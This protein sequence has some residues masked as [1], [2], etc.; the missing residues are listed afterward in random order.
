MRK[1]LYWYGTVAGI[2]VC[3][4]WCAEAQKDRVGR[5]PYDC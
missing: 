5:F 4:M 3:I 1:L 2:L